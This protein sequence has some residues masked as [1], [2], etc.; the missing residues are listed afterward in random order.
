MLG[1]LVKAL[2]LENIDWKNII[3]EYL[4]EAFHEVNLKAFEKGLNQ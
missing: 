2:D 1:A 3:K 4:P